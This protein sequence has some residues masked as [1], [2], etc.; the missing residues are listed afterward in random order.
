M[1]VSDAPRMLLSGGKESQLLKRRRCIDCYL[2]YP[3]LQICNL[4]CDSDV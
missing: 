4:T 2:L 3:L 1:S